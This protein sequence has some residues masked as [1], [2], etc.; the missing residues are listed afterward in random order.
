MKRVK[1]DQKERTK[2]QRNFEKNQ[3]IAAHKNSQRQRGDKI[4]AAQGT[5]STTTFGPFV[6]P[7]GH[8]DLLLLL[9]LGCGPFNIIKS[10]AIASP[11]YHVVSVIPYF[12]SII[13]RVA[14]RLI[15]QYSVIVWLSHIPHIS[16]HEGESI[17]SIPPLLSSVLIL[18][19]RPSVAP[20][21]GT[22]TPNHIITISRWL[23]NPLLPFFHPKRWVS[24]LR[25][26]FFGLPPFSPH[27]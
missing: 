1:K 15:H 16:R 2:E 12:L 6:S 18:I 10:I 19:N 4:T 24:L 11:R 17:V 25:L 8:S 7:C 23:P 14:T 9:T 27:H 5:L 22:R 21:K 26:L 13:R 20:S 3:R